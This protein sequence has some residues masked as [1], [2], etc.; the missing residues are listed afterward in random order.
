MDEFFLNGI[1][2]NFWNDD[3]KFFMHIEWKKCKFKKYGIL[4]LKFKK[5]PSS[6]EKFKNKMHWNF[7]NTRKFYF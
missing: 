6:N 3:T 5:R 4:I 7:L 2:M 1:I